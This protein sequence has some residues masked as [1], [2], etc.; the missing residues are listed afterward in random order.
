MTWNDQ[1]L[2]I[3]SARTTGG[4]ETGELAAGYPGQHATVDDH[5]PVMTGKGLLILEGVQPAG[6]IFM[7]GAVFLR[8]ARDWV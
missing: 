5:P 4:G 7:P 6:K 3:F 1:R 2:K 8:G